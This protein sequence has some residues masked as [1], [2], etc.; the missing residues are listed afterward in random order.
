MGS[1]V[2]A[3][4]R[5][6]R[7][8]PIVQLLLKSGPD[9]P[10]ACKRPQRPP[11]GC[12]PTEPPDRRFRAVGTRV[13]GLPPPRP[14]VRMPSDTS[15]SGARSSRWRG[16]SGSARTCA[17]QPS[18]GVRDCMAETKHQTAYRTV[19]APDGLP[20]NRRAGPPRCKQPSADSGIAGRADPAFARIKKPV[21]GNPVTGAH[22]VSF[23]FPNSLICAAPSSF[24]ICHPTPSALKSR[25][26][27]MPDTTAV[28]HHRG[29]LQP[30]FIENTIWK[31]W[32]AD[33]VASKPC[34]IGGAGEGYCCA[35]L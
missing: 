4:F 14:G 6:G 29:A 18:R 9:G 5:R 20:L 21:S 22:F 3:P 19:K 25:R 24:A 30:R 33:M 11:L 32:I 17:I 2:P 8:D 23:N 28:S 12:G 7:A 13:G 1:A 16:A 15:R 34:S 35:H 31:Q 26:H 10:G 27:R